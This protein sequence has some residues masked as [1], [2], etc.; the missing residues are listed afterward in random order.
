MASIS[1]E[2]NGRRTIQFVAADGKRKSIRLGK[3]SQ[4]VAEAVKVKVE[5][6]SAAVAA[7]HA[8]D[9]ETARWVAGLNQALADKLSA[10]GLI[11]RR[12]KATMGA[13]LDRYFS[14]RIDVKP[15]TLTVW[16][17]TRRNLL[18]FFGRDKALREITQG[19]AESWRLSLVA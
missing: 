2:K 1:R 5:Q 17:H 19:D 10:V 16:G 18:D 14:T 13:F 4:R 8:P 9:N 15:A 3:T 12:E 7:G 6:L 11:P